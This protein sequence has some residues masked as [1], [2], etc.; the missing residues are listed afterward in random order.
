LPN[1]EQRVLLEQI[2][3]LQRHKLRQRLSSVGQ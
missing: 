3:N 2:N 1:N